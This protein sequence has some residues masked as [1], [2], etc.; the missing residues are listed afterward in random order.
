ML[1]KR[2][3]FVGDKAVLSQIIM[4]AF[5]GILSL[6]IELDRM[7]IIGFLHSMWWICLLISLAAFIVLIVSAK[8][9]YYKYHWRVSFFLF[10]LT[11]A[12]LV[13]LIGVA[14][15]YHYVGLY[16]SFLI[17]VF[18]MIII[19]AGYVLA[20]YLRNRRENITVWKVG[21]IISLA[22]IICS[23]LLG[24]AVHTTGFDEEHSTRVSI[25]IIVIGIG[26]VLS[27][28]LYY[29]MLE[30]LFDPKGMD[31]IEDPPN[32][33]YIKVMRISWILCFISWFLFLVLLPPVA[34]GGKG[35]KGGSSGGGGRS[36]SRYS[37]SRNYGRYKKKKSRLQR[38][39]EEWKEYKL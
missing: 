4:F 27:M 33:L 12:P 6:I 35:K 9:Q 15:D 20:K 14:M 2:T 23:I 39:E 13:T 32:E 19:G 22:I 30:S 21:C 1:D 17:S 28:A 25:Y 3:Y 7:L 16:N 24:Y 29:Y 34:G 26:I 10:L 38:S 5:S 31:V 36:S 8:K 37:T 11:W 18:L